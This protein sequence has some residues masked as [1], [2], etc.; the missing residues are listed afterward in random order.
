MGSKLAQ[1][2]V[3]E[4]RMPLGAQKAGFFGA[5]GAASGGGQIGLFWG[6]DQ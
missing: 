2:W 3:K 5:G 6:G 1:R 4:N